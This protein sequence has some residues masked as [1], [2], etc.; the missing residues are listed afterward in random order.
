MCNGRRA[1]GPVAGMV[2]DW[3]TA[4][5]GVGVGRA[6]YKKLLA[7]PAPPLELFGSAVALERATSSGGGAPLDMTVR[8][9]AYL[10]NNTKINNKYQSVARESNKA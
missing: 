1:A 8:S 5:E 4:A 2:L 9:P 7:L 10:N 3:V 6:L